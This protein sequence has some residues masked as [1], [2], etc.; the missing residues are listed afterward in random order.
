MLNDTQSLDGYSLVVLAAVPSVP[1]HVGTILKRFVENGG[2]LLV[3]PWTG[4]QTPEGVF[5][6]GGL[7]S[8]L[9]SL[10][11]I[12]SHSVRW[13]DAAVRT[14]APLQ[15]TWPGRGSAVEATGWAETLR[16]IEAKVLAN[17]CAP[18]DILDGLPAA[19]E[20]QHGQGSV[21][22]LGFWPADDSL[23]ELLHTWLGG[24][25]VLNGP[26]PPGVLVAPRTDGSHFVVNMTPQQVVVVADRPTVDRLQGARFDA[27]VE[28]GP[29]SVLWPE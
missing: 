28:L 17:Y 19:L 13:S 11:G 23:V 18:G 14:G 7:G 15:V 20:R 5:L 22:K 3:T 12:I 10:T 27:G 25:R 21:L 26:A 2:K 8:G 4:Y 29:F 1:S 6:E 16:N 9:S 24:S